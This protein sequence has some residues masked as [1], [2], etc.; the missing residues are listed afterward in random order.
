MY[1]RAFRRATR[2]HC[3][4]ILS[5]AF[6]M[7]T[8]VQ[9]G[10]TSTELRKPVNL[11]RSY[12]SPSDFRIV[13]RKRQWNGIH[14]CVV[15]AVES[16]SEFREFL[17]VFEYLFCMYVTN[18]YIRKLFAI[19]NCFLHRSWSSWDR[20]CL[21]KFLDAC[22]KFYLSCNIRFCGCFWLQNSRKH[23]V[24][25][26]IKNAWF[27]LPCMTVVFGGKNWL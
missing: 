14:S 5:H 26:W 2:K 18:F 25:N 17:H 4:T 3:I 6:P 8:I 27:A 7:R 19:Q 1:T 10:I 13:D 16:H 23:L 12:S 21:T 22:I 24:L 15:L 20:Y 11:S 9:N